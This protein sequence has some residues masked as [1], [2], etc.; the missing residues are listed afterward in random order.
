MRSTDPT[1]A[2]MFG[3]YEKHYVPG[4]ID[5]LADL[6]INI[7]FLRNTMSRQVV[8]MVELEQMPW[9]T[10]KEGRLSCESQDA[11]D[12]VFLQLGGKIF[13]EAIQPMRNRSK[14]PRRGYGELVSELVSFARKAHAIAVLWRGGNGV[15][16]VA[17]QIRKVSGFGGKGF[18]MKEIV[19]D[20]SEVTS[21]EFPSVSDQLV[22]W[23]VVGPGPRRM[24]NWL[25]NRRW[26]DNEQDALR[27][28]TMYIDELREFKNYLQQKTNIPE[29]RALNLLGVQFALCEASKYIF[30]L[31]TEPTWTE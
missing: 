17:T 4:N 6:V 3:H 21:R 15:Q 27:T 25:H 9:L 13:F 1:S 14:A 31:E 7:V 5:S 23:S 18:R 12:K 29:L 28:E 16:Q 20:L 2:I 26:F 30:Y 10:V 8:K 22:D 19:L 11:A 24:L